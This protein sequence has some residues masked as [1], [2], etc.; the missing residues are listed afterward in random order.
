MRILIMNFFRIFLLLLTFRLH[1][2]LI[3]RVRQPNGML[4]R[5]QINGLNSTLQELHSEIK[6]H[7]EDTNSCN[8]SISGT[9][10]SFDTLKDIN[11]TIDS[12]KLKSGDVVS[13]HR[14][15]KVSEI[16]RGESTSRVKIQAKKASRAS[17]A[18]LEKRKKGLFQLKIP[19]ADLLNQLQVSN[20]IERILTRIGHRGGIALLLGHVI[21][22]E[23]NTASA[24][25]NTK[26][27][28]VH[29]VLAAAE[30]EC[31]NIPQDLLS[32]SSQVSTIRRIESIASNLGL[33]VLGCCMSTGDKNL[34]S[35]SHVFAGIQIQHILGEQICPFVV[36]R[37]KNHFYE[38][39]VAF[40]NN[41]GIFQHL[42]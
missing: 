37:Y 27:I 31:G 20:T 2:P 42:Q 28:A 33:K 24:N 10:F 1:F 9:A 13:L 36:L 8:I 4:V 34:W 26:S 14:T 19:K 6:K 41:G 21:K 18:D 15:D 35:E 17:I 32:S 5:V 39:E 11:S 25:K 12:L 30:I 23:T 16:S 22:N 7:I 38:I 29:K 40:I 3:L